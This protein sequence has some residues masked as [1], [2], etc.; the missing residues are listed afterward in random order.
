MDGR[1]WRSTEDCAI[2]KKLDKQTNAT[3]TNQNLTDHSI[4]A[5]ILEQMLMNKKKCHLEE[6]AVQVNRWVKKKEMK[7]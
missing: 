1:E 2:E 5:R 7:R 6:F 4:L 3:S